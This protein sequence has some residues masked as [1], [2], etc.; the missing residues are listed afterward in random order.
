MGVSQFGREG[1]RE[2]VAPFHFSEPEQKPAAEKSTPKDES[3][4]PEKPKEDI[5]SDDQ[6]IKTEKPESPVIEKSVT[7]TQ[8]TGLLSGFS[9]SEKLLLAFGVILLGGLVWVL[10]Y[11]LH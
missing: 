4:K 7:H 2:K 9:L 5:K 10:R 8:K 1:K 11:I 6:K 3:K